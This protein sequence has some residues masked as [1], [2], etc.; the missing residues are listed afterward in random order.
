MISVR[1]FGQNWKQNQ[2]FEGTFSFLIP[3]FIASSLCCSCRSPDETVCAILMTRSLATVF[4]CWWSLMAA[5]WR[6]SSFCSVTDQKSAKLHFLEMF[7]GQSWIIDSSAVSNNNLIGLSMFFE[8]ILSASAW[9]P[10][11]FERISLNYVDEILS[12]MIRFVSSLTLFL[13]NLEKYYGNKTLIESMTSSYLFVSLSLENTSF[14]RQ[15]HSVLPRMWC[16]FTQ[17]CIL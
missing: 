7:T 4:E 16:L 6:L 10:V 3:A 11:S 9:S 17:F 2:D 15:G 12:C 14:H 8:R 13:Q 5:A 1:I